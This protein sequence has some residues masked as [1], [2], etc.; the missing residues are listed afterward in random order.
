[1]TF[2]FFSYQASHSAS[3]CASGLGDAYGET[4][5]VLELRLEE[6]ATHELAEVRLRVHV[7]KD[8][9]QQI[10]AR[11]GGGG[12]ET[13]DDY[14]PFADGDRVVGSASRRALNFEPHVGR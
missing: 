1:V 11:H 2:F 6:D 4:D 14:V 8:Q 12:P 5:E 7:M 10:L 3:L 9:L 13:P